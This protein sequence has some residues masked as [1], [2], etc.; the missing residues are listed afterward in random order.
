MNNSIK[1]VA[2][3]EY[4]TRVKSKT[5][6]VTTILAPLLIVAVMALLIFLSTRGSDE[7][8]NIAV[9]N[10]SD[11]HIEKIAQRKNLNFDYSYHSLESALADYKNKELDGVLLFPSVELSETDYKLEFYSDDQLA[12]D[13][14]LTIE[15]FS[16]KEVRKYRINAFGLDEDQLKLIDADVIIE[17]K[18]VLD[19]EKE[20]SSITSIVTS[21][22]GGVV[23]YGLFFIIVIYGSMVMRSVTEEK[24][25]RIVEV[26]ISTI[27][28]FDLMMGKVI[29]VGLVGLTQICIWIILLLIL[30]SI[31]AIFLGDLLLETAAAPDITQAVP[32][33]QDAGKETQE[34]MTQIFKE[35]RSINWLKIIPLYLFYFL[36]GYFTYAALF[37]AIG[38]AMGDDI[39]EAQSLTMIATMP[40]MVSLY[41]GVSAVSAPNSTLSI[42]SSILPF[43][44]PVVMPIRL[45]IDPPFWQIGLSVLVS[46][47]TVIFLVWLAAR[48]YRVG[49]L[50]YGKKASFKELVKW[51]T[52]K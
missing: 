46:V 43:T 30:T 18:T 17:P 10:V 7:S 49:I 19:T 37:A 3:R 31:G 26:L 33:M 4:L 13:E 40:L 16:K 5:F 50:M 27:R 51:I 11:M 45:P 21:G 15:S 47:L 35:I 42:W 29:G 14:I 1:Q 25:N 23:G 34:K 9:L 36:V 24:I 12:I 32:E 8:K 48:I 44:A 6:L 22:L 20:I 39:Q 38:S 52:Y 2:K 41:I 28:P